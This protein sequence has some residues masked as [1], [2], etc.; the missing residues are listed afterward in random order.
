ML[1]QNAPSLSGVDREAAVRRDGLSG[2]KVQPFWRA[3]QERDRKKAR[4]P[5]PLSATS[6][7]R[8]H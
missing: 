8:S 1:V 6:H 4:Q 7:P 3:V 2:P 5:N